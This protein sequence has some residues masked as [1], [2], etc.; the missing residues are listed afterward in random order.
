M[1]Y[2]YSVARAR[3]IL[4]F[5]LFVLIIASL[6]PTQAQA[7]ASSLT[8]G[9][10]QLVSSTRINRTVYE[11]T[12]KA[13]VTNNG[14]DA[15]KVTATLNIDAP[16][17]TVLDGN[18][19]F[20]D[21]TTGS[22]VTSTDTFTIQQDRT[23]SLSESQF[24]WQ[25][26]A[27]LSESSSFEP[28]LRLQGVNPSSAA[29]GTMVEIDYEAE[30]LNVNSIQLILRN[31]VVIPDGGATGK[32]YFRVPDD[33]TGQNTLFLQAGTVESNAL[34]FTVSETTSVLSPQPEDWVT[35]E[36]DGSQVAVN[37]VL[38]FVQEGFD[39]DSVANAAAVSEG[40]EV[41]GH[42]D[43]LRARQLRLPTTNYEQLEAAVARLETLSGI[44]NVIMDIMLEPLAGP[45]DWSKDPDLPGQRASNRVE[46]GVQVYIDSVHPTSPGKIRPFFR[47]IGVFEKKIRFG[48]KDYKSYALKDG[49]GGH[50]PGEIAL[51][52]PDCGFFCIDENG[53]GSNVLG[54]IAATLGNGGAAGLLSAIGST[55]AHG[56]FNIK[57]SK[58]G[59]IIVLADLA[60]GLESGVREFNLSAGATR[61][62]GFDI[63]SIVQS[64]WICIESSFLQ[65][66]GQVAQSNSKTTSK[67]KDMQDVFDEAVKLLAKYPDAILIVAA[68]N[69]NTSSDSDG[70]GL[71]STHPSQPEQAKGQVIVVG[72]HDNSSMPS[73]YPTSHYGERVD[74]AAAG[75]IQGSTNSAVSGT[76]FATPLVTATIAAMR[77][78]EP[79]LT[80]SEVLDI[81]RSTALPIHNNVVK[82]F[83]P[84]GSS[85][86]CTVFVRPLT[87]EVDA[88]GCRSGP[89]AR[90]NVEGAINA[91][92]A[93]RGNRTRREGDTV[94]VTVTG[95]ETV[96]KEINVTVPSDG[97]VFNRVDIMF[98][99]DVSGSY[100]SS[101]NQFKTQALELVN[102]FK[103]SGSDV[104]IG[105]A[106]FSDFPISPWSS[107]GSDYAFRLDQKLTDDT[108]AVITAINGLNLLSG[109]DTPESQL[110]ALFQ[111]ATGAGRTISGHPQATIASSS[112]GWRDGSLRVIFLAT[113]ANFHNAETG[114]S[115]YTPGYPGASWSTTLKELNDR[116]IHVYGLERGLRVTDVRRIVDETN[117][118][119]FQLDFSSSNIV[120]AVLQTMGETAEKLDIK[121]AK[122]GDFAGTIQ[123]IEPAIFKD[124]ARGETRTF[125]VTFSRGDGGPGEHVFAFRLEAVGADT[126]VIEEIPV[127]IELK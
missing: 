124:V 59:S 49:R 91:A 15:T 85:R 24:I 38:I 46:E 54:P 32:I 17:V 53:H 40:G 57:V 84:D 111:L 73:R 16:G 42:I 96:T 41:V 66:N 19:D 115:Q 123:S 9:N 47:S 122:N 30:N 108:N 106:S 34:L 81:L 75:L 36:E 23:Y 78:I 104:H 105:V 37:F 4:V 80:P 74:I 117:G 13:T 83:N 52:A 60:L 99:V 63:L 67:F 45:V 5:S 126:A 48:L 51:Y 113:D 56:G 89:G 8:V 55:G 119:V 77:S 109:G 71:Y 95:K 120:D 6:L 127:V 79:D 100:G 31:E 7:D 29:P 21:V 114:S 35:L 68:G 2:A 65:S 20:G 33:L 112:T 58:P 87:N 26:E 116:G 12:Y 70:A 101:I 93:K 125:T 94:N 121:L 62:D 61:C 86:G 76:S 1:T 50:R 90:L 10:Y 64:K 11:Y 28:V 72:E 44:E 25:V 103:A 102:A 110:E 14:A 18:L 92:I 27:Q 22:T 39:P 82:L 118:K 98:L 88:D 43:A 107:Y 3:A 69:G 97:N